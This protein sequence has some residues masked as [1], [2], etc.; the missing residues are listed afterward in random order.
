MDMA[1]IRAIAESYAT[2]DGYCDLFGLLTEWKSTSQRLRLN[3]IGFSDL[4]GIYWKWMRFGL[5]IEMASSMDWKVWWCCDKTIFT[6]SK[7]EVERIAEDD[8]HMRA[9]LSPRGSEAQ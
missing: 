1:S 6:L 2:S 4:E 3:V 9:S 7:L 5:S 8:P